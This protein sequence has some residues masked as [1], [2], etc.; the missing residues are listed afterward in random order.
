MTFVAGTTY[1]E[2]IRE[3]AKLQMIGYDDDQKAL[4]LHVHKI[5][6]G[7][8]WECEVLS[9][10]LLQRVK[11]FLQYQCIPYLLYKQEER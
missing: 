7:E 8:V 2:M 3:M 10:G 6:D 4:V 9:N 11:T 5:Q 1:F